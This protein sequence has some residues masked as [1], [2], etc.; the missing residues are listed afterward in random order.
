MS[1][2]VFKGSAAFKTKVHVS[3]GFNRGL[4]KGLEKVC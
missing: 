1:S 3:V 2:K 4:G